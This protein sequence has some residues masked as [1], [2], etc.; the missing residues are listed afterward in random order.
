MHHQTASF[1]F[2]PKSPVENELAKNG[3][4]IWETENVVQNVVICLQKKNNV[5]VI[6]M[7]QKQMWSPDE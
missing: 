5:T 2:F 1:S 3:L 6:I 7:T 4:E